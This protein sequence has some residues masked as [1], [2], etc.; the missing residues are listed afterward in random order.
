MLQ[1][2]QIWPCK[3]CPPH[4]LKLC[5]P[6]SRLCT[7]RLHYSFVPDSAMQGEEHYID[8][9]TLLC[10]VYWICVY[11]MSGG[12]IACE[13]VCVS[14]REWW[15][16]SVTGLGCINR[17]PLPIHSLS[18]LNK[19]CMCVCPLAVEQILSLS[20]FTVKTSC[21]A[22]FALT[23]LSP[24]FPSLLSPSCPATLFLS[25]SLSCCLSL[26]SLCCSL[27]LSV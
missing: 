26:L 13:F 10:C 11:L 6:Y 14:G 23:S 12:M 2:V 3:S 4:F 16:G 25:L 17:S 22:P 7:I 19:N 27:I 5:P 24:S 1:E 8:I 21:C 9:E 20:S 15:L 18:G